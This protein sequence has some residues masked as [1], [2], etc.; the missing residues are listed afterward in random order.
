MR[1]T[2][3]LVAKN[4]PQTG[5]DKIT[6]FKEDYN[7][8]DIIDCILLAYKISVFQSKTIST[9]F[10]G[11]TILLTAQK[12]FDFLMQEVKYKRD[13]ANAQFVRKPA[14]LMLDGK[15]DCKSLS[16]FTA[17]VLHHL[18]IPF[19]FR[20]TSYAYSPEVYTHVYVICGSK[21]NP[22]IIDRVWKKFNSEKQ[23]VKHKDFW[24]NPKA[25]NALEPQIGGIGALDRLPEY[26]STKGLVMV[27]AIN[28]NAEIGFFKTKKQKARQAEQRKKGAEIMAR[29]LAQMPNLSID[30]NGFMALKFG[31]KSDIKII[32]DKGSHQQVWVQELGRNVAFPRKYKGKLRVANGTNDMPWERWFRSEN[33]YIALDNSKAIGKN[34]YAL[35]HRD[36]HAGMIKLM[37]SGVTPR[38]NITVELIKYYT[39]KGL[40]DMANAIKEFGPDSVGQGLSKAG[41]VAFDVV[42]TASSFVPGLNAAAIP[43]KVASIA[44][45]VSKLASKGIKAGKLVAKGL[46]S[47]NKIKGGLS[48]LSKLK[49]VG[50]KAISKTSSKLFKVKNKFSNVVSKVNKAKGKVEK[51]KSKYD[52]IR[53]KLNRFAPENE[54]REN[55]Q[56][57]MQVTA[58]NEESETDTD[59][60][61][62]NFQNQDSSEQEQ[63]E[64]TETASNEDNEQD[65]E[66]STDAEMGSIYLV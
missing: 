66:N 49:S 4:M 26:N 9:M 19:A 56:K 1:L 51:V 22:V 42:T 54:E 46:K 29:A 18:G 2:R 25:P 38:R 31:I 57:S 15:G 7:T 35:V 28:E 62:D 52:K 36:D 32:T 23:Y 20:F 14:Q 10:A 40:G 44:S 13:P 33:G 50:Q 65:N 30:K 27:G 64:T 3:N 11:K 8:L 55:Y 63:E 48:K 45:K 58:S 43:L 39:G 60:D 37:K 24:F 12:I 17:S 5:A 41:A 34:R 53:E 16:L 59:S 21:Q 61:N 47:A 6:M